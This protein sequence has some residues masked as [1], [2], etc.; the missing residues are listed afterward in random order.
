VCALT[1]PGTADLSA[2]VDFAAFAR[3]ARASGA[4]TH[5]PVPQARLLVALGARERAAALRARATPNQ[6]QTLDSGLGRLLDPD[7]MGSRFKAVALVSPGL[8]MPPGFEADR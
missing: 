2:H 6:R 7:G 5:G 8:P 1:A 4:E 3:A